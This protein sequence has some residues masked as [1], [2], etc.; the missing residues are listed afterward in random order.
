MCRLSRSQGTSPEIINSYYNSTPDMSDDGDDEAT[1]P[2]DA[3]KKKRTTRPALP[4]WVLPRAGYKAEHK[5]KKSAET[6]VQQVLANEKSTGTGRW[7]LF[8]EKEGVSM[9][10]DAQGAMKGVGV[11]DNATCAE[12]LGI[13]LDLDVKKQL[14]DVFK[15]GSTL[16]TL[17]AQSVIQHVEFHR[18]WPTTARDFVLLR[19]IRCVTHPAVGCV[20]GVHMCLCVCVSSFSLVFTSPTPRARM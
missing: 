16:E 4:N 6:M 12:M 13:V 10:K 14:D 1:A 7:T 5:Y 11:V 2:E 18:S 9:Y 19:H 3:E 15:K 17:D 20:V 8:D